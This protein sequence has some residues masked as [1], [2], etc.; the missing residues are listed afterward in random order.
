MKDLGWIEG[1]KEVFS[2]RGKKKE[3]ESESGDS[4]LEFFLLFLFLFFNDVVVF[5][6]FK[7]GERTSSK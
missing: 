4:R 2:R 1:K 5:T 6:V 3:V 7:L